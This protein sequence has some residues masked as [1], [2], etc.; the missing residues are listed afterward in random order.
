M[1]QSDFPKMARPLI[2]AGLT[3]LLLFGIGS[4]VYSG[5]WSQG[6]TMGLLTGSADGADLTP[7]LVYRTGGWQGG[8]FGFFG[9]IFRIFFFVFLF[10]L[11]FKALGIWRWRMHGGPDQ[12]GAGHGPWGRHGE[13]GDGQPQPPQQPQPEAPRGQPAQPDQPLAPGPQPTSW[14]R[15]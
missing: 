10:G 13:W 14:T 8:G 15:V 12:W 11:L 7:Y 2:F 5:G 9:A 4:A 1:S 6:Y 3:L